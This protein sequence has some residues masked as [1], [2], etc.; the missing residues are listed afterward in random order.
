MQSEADENPSFEPRRGKRTR[1]VGRDVCYQLCFSEIEEDKKGLVRSVVM[2]GNAKVKDLLRKILEEHS[3]LLKGADIADLIAYANRDDIPA[4]NMINGASPITASMGTGIE[5]PIWI[6]I[7]RPPQITV[8]VTSRPQGVAYPFWGDVDV[9]SYTPF[10]NVNI[11]EAFITLSHEF[12]E[13]SGLETKERQSLTFY[14]RK[15]AERE[16]EF[17]DKLL[18]GDKY[19][20][21]ITNDSEDEEEGEEKSDES[22]EDH[23]AAVENECSLHLEEDTNINESR[24]DV[25]MDKSN[26]DCPVQALTTELNV[27]PLEK[28]QREEPVYRNYNPSGYIYGQ[29]GTGKSTTAYLKGASLSEA[30]RVIWIHSEIDRDHARVVIMHKN[31]KRHFEMDTNEILKDLDFSKE[32]YKGLKVLLLLDSLDLS[33]PQRRKFWKLANDWLRA[34]EKNRRLIAVSSLWGLDLKSNEPQR[35]PYRPHPV[36]GWKLKDYIRAVGQDRVH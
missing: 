27:E 32:T 2:D 7:P 12:L 26:D 30:Y 25:E 29:P 18:N 15:E 28:E 22:D 20:P 8:G 34:D 4:S 14:R 16:M 6:V 13:G 9:G 10:E 21:D 19:M 23:A 36:L 17:I 35:Y 24:G 31:K 5:N 11:M 1:D 33:D 3:N